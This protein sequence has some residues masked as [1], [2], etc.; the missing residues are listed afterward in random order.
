MAGP[1]LCL[2]GKLGPAV[3]GA[4][5]ATVGRPWSVLV[6][7]NSPVAG[8]NTPLYGQGFKVRTGQGMGLV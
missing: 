2:M 6:P 5:G 4:L 3:K 1:Y 8:Q 7:K